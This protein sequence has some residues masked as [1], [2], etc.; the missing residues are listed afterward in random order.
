MHATAKW[1]LVGLLVAAGSGCTS[2]RWNLAKSDVPQSSVNND[3]VR[4]KYGFPWGN[5]S[6]KSPQRNEAL[7]ADLQAKMAEARSRTASSAGGSNASVPDLLRQAALAENSRDL[8]GAKQLYLKVVETEPRNAEAHHRLGVIADQQRDTVAADQHYAQALA[9]N[10]K[11]SDLLHDVGYSHL[12][13]GNL[14]DSER[15]LKEALEVNSFNQRASEHLGQV[16][17]RQ[18]RYD[19]ALAMFRQCATEREAQ[20]M[21]AQAFPNGRSAAD[22]AS[23]IAAA[24]DQHNAPRSP[25]IP[26]FSQ[27]GQTLDQIQQLMAQERAA[28]QRARD[29]RMQA[30]MRPQGEDYGNPQGI[31]PNPAIARNNTPQSPFA[32]AAPS[33]SAAA[34]KA[35]LSQLAGTLLPSVTPGPASAPLPQ[36]SPTTAPSATNAA[37]AGA[38]TWATGSSIPPTGLAAGQPTPTNTWSVDSPAHAP[39]AP[40][41]A[42]T[43]P[44]SSQNAPTFWQGALA[45][46]PPAHATQPPAD[47]ATPYDTARVPT[48]PG[49]PATPSPNLAWSTGTSTVLPNLTIPPTTPA[50]AVHAAYQA[51]GY[52]R[53]MPPALPGPPASAGP[54]L[55]AARWAAQ[56]AMGAG[57]GAMFPTVTQMSHTSGPADVRFSYGDAPAGAP[58]NQVSTAVWSSDHST[59]TNSIEPMGGTSNIAPSSPWNNWQSP[60]PPS[61]NWM[62]PTDSAPTPAAA[63]PGPSYWS[64]S[65]ANQPNGGHNAAPA[66]WPSTPAATTRATQTTNALD[67]FEAELRNAAGSAPGATSTYPAP[68]T[69]QNWPYP[70]AR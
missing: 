14:E 39:F 31:S 58:R 53:Q 67:A 64:G 28:A 18:G 43:T 40:N 6:K 60:S 68:T 26:D 35:T 30:E 37:A 23:A 54:Q 50:P 65:A 44:A 2:S 16:Y 63:Q 21:I 57:P 10:R 52:D 70:P 41:A 24:S 27:G 9:I 15:Y 56:M 49:P 61:T 69:I 48:L 42:A 36:A 46:T 33:T 66:P 34:A 45:N 38:P 17:A 47:G 3:E 62:T 29:Q 22:G 32:G 5:A 20:Q 51:T 1:L 11:D 12:L 55:D 4:V 7:A 13:R 25:S 19:A 59:N 8:A